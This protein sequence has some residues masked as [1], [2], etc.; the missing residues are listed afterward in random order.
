MPVRE[1]SIYDLVPKAPAP[2]RKPF[3]YKSK[4]SPK[5]APSY[6]T[7]GRSTGSQ[8]FVTNVGGQSLPSDPSHA[9]KA[10]GANMGGAKK[11]VPDF[12]AYKTRKSKLT[13]ELP[14]PKKFSYQSR[15]KPKLDAKLTRKTTRKPKKNFITTNAAEAIL[16]KTSKKSANTGPTRF[17]K[18]KDYGR[19]PDYL[20]EVK[21]D[22]EAEKQFIEKMIAESQAAEQKT[23][24]LTEEEREELLDGLK[25]KWEAVNEKYQK[26]THVV[27]LDTM[28]KV[29]RKEQY[30][31]EL[32]DLEK[33]ITKLSRRVV[34]VQD[35]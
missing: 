18:K 15:R 29:R 22:I 4:F 2:K 10:A 21:A 8:H 6:S 9:H 19:V 23:R 31:S 11:H 27:K 3:R 5:S 13:K 28:S 25:L 20:Q 35:E 32:D 7:F 1:E 26:I 14:K 24:V 30:E 12:Q 33:A 17:V 16:R 34:I